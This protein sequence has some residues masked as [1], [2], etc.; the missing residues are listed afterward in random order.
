MLDVSSMDQI[1]A[2]VGAY[3]GAP[4]QVLGPHPAASNGGLVVRVF[5]PFAKTVT[6][7]SEEAGQELAMRKV[8]EGGIFEAMLPQAKEPLRYRLG[9][10]EH[11]GVFR[12]VDDPYRFPPQ[13]TD[14]DLYLLGEGNHFKSYEKLGAHLREVD[15]VRGVLFALWAPNAMRV[16]VVG[17]FNRWDGRIHPMDRRGNSGIWELF[18]PGLHQGELY[19]FEVKSR[20][21]GYMVEKADPYAFY[22]EL[23]PR[24]ASIVWDIDTYQWAD[25]DWMH[26]RA[27]GDLLAKPM[28]VYEVHL[29]SWRRVPEEGNRWLSYRELAHRLVDYV[30]DMGYTHVELLPISEHP[31]DGSWGYQVSGYFAPTSRFG[32][33]D[34]FKYFVDYCHQHG[35]GVILDWVPAHFPKDAYALGYFDGTHLYEHDDPRLGEHRDWGTFIFNFGRNEVRNFLLSN[36]LY[37]LDKYHIDGLRVDAVASMLYLDYSREAGQW[38]PNRFGGRENLEAVTFV[39]QF[40]ELVHERFP[41]AMT[42]AEESTS[43]PQVSR[44]VYTGGLGFTFKWNMGWMHDMLEYISKDAIFRRYHH[45]SISFSM[46]YAFTENF[47]LPLSHD[48]VVHGKGSL[49]GKMPGDYWQKFANMRAFFG[50]MFTHPG[51]KLLFQGGDIGQWNEWNH[52]ASVEWNLLEFEPHRKLQAFVRDLNR[53]YQ[54]QPALYE[55]DFNWTGFQWLSINDSDNSVI[56]FVRRGK[57]PGEEL[58]VACNFTPVVRAGYRIPVPMLG[59]YRELLNS[60]SE[61]YGGS[62]VGN[63]GELWAEP[64]PW[65]DQGMEQSLVLT[66]PPLAT[67]VLKR[68]ED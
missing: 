22:S 36:A 18:V 57:T 41:G 63:G 67:V 5:Q 53:L 54:S 64:T 12:V 1:E 16:S 10:T 8:H 23:R 3:H 37:W 7:L 27:R 25:A 61:H 21:L 35:V 50:Y 33:P 30:K 4:R 68:A 6:L 43:W 65:G 48:E 47:V 51:K 38:I 42:I 52:D 20:H 46:L 14:F 34:D 13:L 15:G 11:D 26:E 44:P 59:R 31:F 56:A 49:L 39:R 62:N 2:I 58:V 32:S 45:H 28:S 9:V 66:L 19:K 17:P 29:G 24:T 40:N 55:D 60:D